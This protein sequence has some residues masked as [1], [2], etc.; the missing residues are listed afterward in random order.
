MLRIGLDDPILIVGAGIC[1]LAIAQGLQKHN[2][3]CLIFDARSGPDESQE[4]WTAVPWSGGQ[5]LRSLLPEQLAARLE[6]YA[7]PIHSLKPEEDET[8][9]G[10][11]WD[12]EQLNREDKLQDNECFSVAEA[13]LRAL[14]HEG[15]DV[16][17][18]GMSSIHT[19]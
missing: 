3:P 19:S 10:F 7:M 5:L 4:N 15:I 16:L 14:C 2:I 9:C 17:V 18:S 12:A 11:P 8:D 13:K 1:G 6:K